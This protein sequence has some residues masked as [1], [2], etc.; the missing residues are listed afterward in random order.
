MRVKDTRPY[1]SLLVWTKV[2]P[3]VE[4]LGCEVDLGVVL[5]RKGA[6][7]MGAES[8]DRP[9][10]RRRSRRPRARAA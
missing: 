5:M 7:E 10:R 6:W 1:I 2:F 9:P 4:R 3:F 8:P